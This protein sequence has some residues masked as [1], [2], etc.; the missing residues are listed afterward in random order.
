MKSLAE[1][2]AFVDRLFVKKADG[3]DGMMHAAIGIAGEAGEIA[4]HVK[5]TWVYDKPLDRAAVIEEIGDE[6]FYLV[7]LCNLLGISLA[8]A[9]AGNVSK[10]LARYPEGYSDRAAIERADKAGVAPGNYPNRR[11]RSECPY[12]SCGSPYICR[13]GCRHTTPIAAEAEHV[14]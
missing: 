4:D 9:I 1:Y 6:V 3:I 11:A 12:V 14:D 7:A 10:L 13:R 2:A 5:K 8:D